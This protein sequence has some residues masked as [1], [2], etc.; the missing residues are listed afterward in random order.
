MFASEASQP[1]GH[2]RLNAQSAPVTRI[3][4]DPSSPGGINQDGVGDWNI[5]QS[6]FRD[7]GASEQ[8]VVEGE[9][10]VSH[11]VHNNR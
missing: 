10:R 4:G 6:G 9:I 5:I 11:A 3:E 7:T 1:N 2:V 8:A